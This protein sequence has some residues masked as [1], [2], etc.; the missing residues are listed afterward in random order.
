MSILKNFFMM[1]PC[2]CGFEGLR[3]ERREDARRPRREV[4]AL[5]AGLL[6]DATQ[7]GPS[8][9]IGDRRERRE[10]VWH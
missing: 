2:W 8:D 5:G 10:R 3:V 9:T 7:A 4:C 1:V 6:N